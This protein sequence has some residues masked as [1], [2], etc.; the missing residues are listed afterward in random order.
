[1]E[2]KTESK[3]MLTIS[4]DEGYKDLTIILAGIDTKRTKEFN[5]MKKIEVTKDELNK[6]GTPRWLQSI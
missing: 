4:K 5:S 6:I 3:S 2:K 1:M